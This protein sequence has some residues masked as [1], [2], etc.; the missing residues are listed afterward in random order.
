MSDLLS[1][2]PEVYLQS[3]ELDHYIP[4]LSRE[5]KPEG[6]DPALIAL[7][8]INNFVSLIRSAA[9]SSEIAVSWRNYIVGA[10]VLAY[11]LDTPAM[12]ATVGGN[13]KPEQT[14]GLNLHAEQIALAKARK[15]KLNCIFG[16]AVWGDPTDLDANPNHSPTRIP[17]RRCDK[18]F[19]ELPEIKPETLIVSSNADLSVCELYTVEELRRYYQNPDAYGPITDMPCYSLAD[20][21]DDIEYEESVFIPYL[22]PKIIDLYPGLKLD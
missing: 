6:Y 10:A 5:L 22:L 15:I 1:E 19:S 2:V 16:I 9:K 12:G 7:A 21:M 18:M 17:C 8:S 13:I 4:L 20:D 11:N 3:H 14:G